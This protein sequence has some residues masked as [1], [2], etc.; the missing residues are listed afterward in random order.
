MEVDSNVIANRPSRIYHRTAGR[1]VRALDA[2]RAWPAGTCLCWNAGFASWTI[3]SAD[4]KT[5]RRFHLDHGPVPCHFVVLWREGVASLAPHG[6]FLAPRRVHSP[7]WGLGAGSSPLLVCGLSPHGALVLWWLRGGGVAQPPLSALLHGLLP[8]QCHRPDRAPIHAHGKR[9]GGSGLSP[10]PRGA[11]R[12]AIRAGVQGEFGTNILTH[13]CL[14]SY[15]GEYINMCSLVY[16]PVY[17]YII[18]KP[19]R[20]DYAREGQG[21]GA[22]AGR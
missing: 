16:E 17:A 13:Q 5:R 15:T 12:R 8:A 18:S 11:R 6:V 14:P 4:R 10:E 19:K 20:R 1:R 2:F 22:P 7:A 3:R 9:S 21:A